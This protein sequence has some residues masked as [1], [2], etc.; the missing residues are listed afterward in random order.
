MVLMYLIFRKREYLHRKVIDRGIRIFFG[1]VGL[2]FVFSTVVPVIKDDLWLI[3]LGNLSRNIPV[4]TGRAAA[5]RGIYWIHQSF[6]F[7][8]D[9]SERFYTLRLTAPASEGREYEVYYLPNSR[10]IIKITEL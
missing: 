3:A 1:L 5:C 10:Q 6:V 4:R 7:E 8:A 9:K 2:V